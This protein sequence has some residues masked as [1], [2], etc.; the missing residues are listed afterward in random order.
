MNEKSL[1][2]MMA[3]YS[4]ILLFVESDRHLQTRRSPKFERKSKIIDSRFASV[5]KL[6]L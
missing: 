5:T 1:L 2:K 3:F 4:D 6:L